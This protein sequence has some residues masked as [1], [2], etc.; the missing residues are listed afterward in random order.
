[1]SISRC[2]SQFRF[3][4]APGYFLTNQGIASVIGLVNPSCLSITGAWNA[5]LL[6]GREL[7]TLKSYLQHLFNISSKT[8]S[9]VYTLISSHHYYCGGGVPGYWLWSP[10]TLHWLCGSP[11]LCCRWWR[12][13][14]LSA[15][16]SWGWFSEG[17]LPVATTTSRNRCVCEWVGGR[18]FVCVLAG[19]NMFH[20]Y[21]GGGGWGGGELSVSLSHN[22]LLSDSHTKHAFLLC[23]WLTWVCLAFALF[24]FVFLPHLS[25]LSFSWRRR[26]CPIAIE[27][28][29]RSPPRSSASWDS[30]TLMSDKHHW[31]TLPVHYLVQIFFVPKL[32][33]E[34]YF[35][36]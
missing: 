13:A 33:T 36:F 8:G 3:S 26:R 11:V 12:R 25:N 27:Q 7:T 10:R 22:A 18:G 2:M 31:H 21:I 32:Q 1:M 14:C 16:S 6:N 20:V 15:V 9:T 17:W 23:A 19:G 5:T 29:R 30:Q 35:Y 4:T 28:G 34:V 24:L